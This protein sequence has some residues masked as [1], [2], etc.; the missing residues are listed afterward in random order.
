MVDGISGW[1]GW[2]TAA[3]SCASGWLD[4]EGP[5]VDA[6]GNNGFGGAGSS[7]VG[8]GICSRMGGGGDVIGEW[9]GVI[10]LVEIWLGEGSWICG[11][12]FSWR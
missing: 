6:V 4:T 8:F 10:G 12:E 3:T 11:G 5:D 1:A 7:V 2:M 9:S